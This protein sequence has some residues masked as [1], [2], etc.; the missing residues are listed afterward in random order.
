[1]SRYPADQTTTV[2]TRSCLTK[3]VTNDAVLCADAKPPHFDHDLCPAAGSYSALRLKQS[4][5][6]S[7]LCFRH[8]IPTDTLTGPMATSRGSRPARAKPDGALPWA[9][10]HPPCRPPRRPRFH[11]FARGAVRGA[12]RG[13]ARGAAPVLLDEEGVWQG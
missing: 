5:I 2:A 10:F 8:A 4:L 11:R 6:A 1:M 7:A 9:T 13:A 3:L 12:V